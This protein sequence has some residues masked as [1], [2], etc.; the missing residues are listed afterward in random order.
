MIQWPLKEWIH[1]LGNKSSIHRLLEG[2]ITHRHNIQPHLQ[3]GQRAQRLRSV[4]WAMVSSIMSLKEA[5]IDTVMA[6]LGC[7]LNYVWNEL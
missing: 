1:Q 4:N 7:Q 5:L 6:I 3:R 2:C